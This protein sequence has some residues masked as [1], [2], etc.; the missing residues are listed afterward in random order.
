M[1]G[2]AVKSPVIWKPACTLHALNMFSKRVW[3]KFIHGH[4][5]EGGGVT[6]NSSF[7]EIEFT[8]ELKLSSF[9]HPHVNHACVMKF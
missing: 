1:A 8:T 5:D 9:T 2:D 4:A 3:H 6:N 7:K